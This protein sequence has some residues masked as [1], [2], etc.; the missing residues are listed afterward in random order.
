M[1]CTH[2]LHELNKAHMYVDMQTYRIVNT[3]PNTCTERHVNTLMC[4]HN[5]DE[6]VP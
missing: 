3:Y 5:T 1:S 6:K 2:R 4:T